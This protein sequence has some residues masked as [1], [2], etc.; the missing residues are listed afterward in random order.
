M[1]TTETIREPRRLTRPRT[2]A[3]S[4]ASPP[5]SARYFD[6]SPTIYRIAFVALA[7]AGGT[8]I[9]L[10][11]AAWLVIPDEGEEDSSR[12]RAQAARD[13]PGRA[14]GDRA[15]RVRR[16]SSR[17]R[18]ANLWPSPGNLWLAAALAGA[19]LV[20]WQLGG[21]TASPTVRRRRGADALPAC[22]GR[23]R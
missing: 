3:G 23:S 9:L 14:I 4:A 12:P 6:L 11:V 21:R 1:E 19:A 8:G 5:G 2:G 10:Y 17:S 16:A 20:W 22:S 15:A 18:S 13:R 7:L